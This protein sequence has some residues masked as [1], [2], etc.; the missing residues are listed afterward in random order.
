VPVESRFRILRPHARGGLGEVFI[1]RDAELNRDVALKEIQARFADDSDS[2]SRF[3]LEAEVTGGLEHPGIVPVY[4]LGQYEDGRPYYAMRFIRGDSLKEAIELF[5][6]AAGQRAP[7][8][9]HGTSDSTPSQSTLPALAFQSVEFRTLLGRFVDVCQAISYAHSRGVLHRDLKPGNIMLGKYGETLVVDWGLAKVQ[10]NEDSTQASGEGVLRP[11]SGSG[12]TPTM[13]GSVIGTPGYMPPEQAMGQLDQLG[14]T[15]DVYSLGATLYHVL[16]GRSAFRGDDYN[17]LLENV[18]A[19]RFEPPR[20]LQGNLPRSLEAVCLKAMSLESANRYSTPQLLADDIER[21]LADEPVSAFAEPVMTRSLRWARKHR[22]V[23]TATAAVVLVLAVSLGMFSTILSSKNTELR[24]TNSQLAE[25]NIRERDAKTLA[26]TNESIARRQSQLALY[27]L[28]A[29]VSDVQAGLD[30]LAGGTDIRRRILKTALEKMESVSTQYIQQSSIDSS[31]WLALNELGEVINEFGNQP[32]SNP[33]DGGGPDSAAAMTSTITDEQSSATRMAESLFL[34]ALEIARQLHKNHPDDAETQRKLTVSLDHLGHASTVLGKTDE[35]L[36]YVEEGLQIR[37]GMLTADPDNVAKQR[38]LSSSFEQLGDVLLELGRTEEAL[39]LFQDKLRIARQLV[40]ADSLKPDYQQNLT[41]AL[42]RLGDVFLKTGHTDDALTHYQEAWI[43]SKALADSHPEDTRHQTTCWISSTTLADVFLILGKT[44][45]AIAQFQEGANVCRR[46]AAVDPRDAEKQRYLAIAVNR[47]GNVLMIQG[48]LDDARMQLQE[49]LQISQALAAADQNNVLYQRDLTVSYELLGR[50]ALSL[51]ETELARTHSENSVKVTRALSESD[52]NN[53]QKL[54]DLAISLE[55]LGQV[56]LA[57]GKTDDAIQYFLEELAIAKRRLQTD[58]SDADADRFVSVVDDF[59]GD[60]YLKLK[61]IDE[62]LTNF[63]NSMA[64]RRRLA[65]VD[66]INA[67]GQNDLALSVDHLGDV[68]LAQSKPAE[69]VKH[70]QEGLE[71]RQRLAKAD[72]SNAERQTGCVVSLYKIGLAWQASDQFSQAAESFDA[73][74]VVLK[75]MIESGM[76]VTQATGYLTTMENLAASSRLMNSA[77]SDWAT[78]LEQPAESLPALLE[79][80]G[81]MMIRRSNPAAAA[82]AANKL[83]ELQNAT[84]MQLYNAACVL[85]LCAAT[86]Q[87]ADGQELDA[88]QSTQREAWIVEALE[89]LKQS[90]EKGWADFA[91]MQQDPD[92][93]ILREHE[94]FKALLPRDSPK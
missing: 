9:G 19:G 22:T 66:P 76:S 91:H 79:T 90:I 75:N 47:I 84:H 13:F 67:D 3:V 59:L 18:K 45:E 69:A 77:L 68:C 14:P 31:T 38:D 56:S 64:I 93:T 70:F 26:Q 52:P 86:V 74:T 12:I 8:S 53:S 65:A 29:V 6:R 33:A 55:R 58:P 39:T 40:E 94:E 57:L 63:Q 25:A 43:V 54:R 16:T 83:R 44:E 20:G 41:I 62:A 37:R 73:G 21:Y 82:E 78:L 35:A 28:T 87:A 60:I 32:S 15:S 92:L 30:G 4:G 1:A 85:S 34:R 36:L 49:G 51:N 27:T 88:A 5:H 71:I 89:T 80:R 10:D 23:T 42:D 24:K 11:S 61:R 7:S 72:L 46:M 81:M 48:R 2:R 50:I 17:A